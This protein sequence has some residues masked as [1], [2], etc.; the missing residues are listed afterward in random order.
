VIY[1]LL[2]QNNRIIIF[3]SSSC[4]V[5]VKEDDK[6]IAVNK[7]FKGNPVLDLEVISFNLYYFNE[8]WDDYESEIKRCKII[9]EFSDIS[10]PEESMNSKG[11]SMLNYNSLMHMQ[12]LLMN[13]KITHKFKIA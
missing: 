13:R 12:I 6:Q 3:T 5:R 10:T 2:S 7:I 9:S 4:Y 1:L 8:R 11:K